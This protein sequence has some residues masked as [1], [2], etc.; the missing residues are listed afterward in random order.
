M[1]RVSSHAATATSTRHHNPTAAPLISTDAQ[2]LAV[3]LLTENL[4]D[5]INI[6]CITLSVQLWPPPPTPPLYDSQ[7][8]DKLHEV[9]QFFLGAVLPALEGVFWTLR[10]DPRLQAAVRG[11]RLGR[12]RDRVGR[13]AVVQGKDEGRIDVRSLALIGFRD[14]LILP[15]LRRLAP[16]FGEIEVELHSRSNSQKT[17]SGGEEQRP[18]TPGRATRVSSGSGHRQVASNASNMT[19]TPGNLTPST[20]AASPLLGPS[21]SPAQSGSS[22]IRRPSSAATSNR[23][24]AR[25]RQLVATLASVLTG[26]DRQTMVEDLL[27][28]MRT[29]NPGSLGD[30]PARHEAFSTEGGGGDKPSWSPTVTRQGSSHRES[31]GSPTE[32]ADATVAELGTALDR[33]GRGRAETMDSI[34]EGD[35]P[36][37]FTLAEGASTF[38]PLAE[39]PKPEAGRSEHWEMPPPPIPTK[40]KKKHHFLGLMKRSHSGGVDREKEGEGLVPGVRRSATLDVVR[41][42]R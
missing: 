34:E 39:H 11:A 37:P 40:E 20:A 19:V 2:S 15:H 28:T 27:R 18:P 3:A 9:W 25:R 10:S 30:R 35:M 24:A 12:E 22:P 38:V 41:G 31:Y 42:G 5:L 16:L 23:A 14:Q 17:Q 32:E 26:D 8:L 36:L 1:Q 6:G 4:T 33:L 13:T 7:L 29:G 21:P